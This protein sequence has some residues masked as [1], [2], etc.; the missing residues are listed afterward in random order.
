MLRRIDCSVNKDGL[1]ADLD[2]SSMSLAM[3]TT[4]L[5]MHIWKYERNISLLGCWIALP[6]TYIRSSFLCKKRS[7]W[8]LRNSHFLRGF[9]NQL[10]FPIRLPGPQWVALV[11]YKELGNYGMGVAAQSLLLLSLQQPLKW[12]NSSVVGQKDDCSEPVRNGIFFCWDTRRCTTYEVRIIVLLSFIQKRS[13][14]SYMHQSHSIKKYVKD[15][16][17]HHRLC[18]GLLFLYDHP[19]VTREK[20]T[21]G[22]K[23]GDSLVPAGPRTAFW[24]RDTT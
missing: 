23:L 20:W 3:S 17:H 18:M 12:G 6:C 19:L 22:L 2:M 21:L 13:S 15:N 4:S 5:L 1:C 7:Q 11:L 24:S 14:Y 10:H 16:G 8:L 9:Q